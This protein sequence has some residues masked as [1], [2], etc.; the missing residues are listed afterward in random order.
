MTTE[1]F[2]E[3]SSGVARA[4]LQSGT[5]QKTRFEKFIDEEGIPSYS[6]IGFHNVRELDL[7]PWARLGG[8]GAYLELSGLDGIKSM[9]VLEIPGGGVLN[10]ERHVFH[11]FY[12]VLEGRGTTETWI[13][14]KRKQIVEWQPGSLF[15]LPPNVH[16]RLVNATNERVLIIAATNAPPIMNM[17]QNMDFI[18]NNDFVFPEHH[19]RTATTR[20]RR[21]DLRHPDDQAR[22][23]AHQLLPRHHQLRAPARQP[24][25]SRLPTG[26]AR[27]AGLPGRGARHLHRPVPARALLAG[28]LSH[29]ARGARLPAGGRLHL[30]LA[31]RVRH[32]SLEGRACRQ[33]QPSRLRAGWPRLGGPGRRGLVPPALRRVGR[34]AQSS[35]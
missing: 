2:E 10:P 12:L 3:P 19:P 16:H 6:A 33:G 13:D 1:L 9:F 11:A 15:Y 21:P 25:H 18:F 8:N 4:G 24:A 34:A 30:Q 29:S 35:T 7:G 22:P 27:V 23:G 14:E 31:A 32:D 28:A 26:A 5:A 20:P 17:F